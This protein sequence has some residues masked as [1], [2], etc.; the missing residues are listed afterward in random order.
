M[1]RIIYLTLLSLRFTNSL[2]G[3]D[4]SSARF[5]LHANIKEGALLHVYLTQAGVHS[6]LVESYSEIDFATMEIEA[7]KEMVVAYVKEHTQIIG[8]GIEMQ[9]GVGA[10]KLGSHETQIKL[11]LKNYPKGVEHLVVTIDAFKENKHHHSLF[12]WHTPEESFRTILSNKND[13]EG[14]FELSPVQPEVHIASIGNGIIKWLFL[15]VGIGFLVLAFFV[16]RQEL[17]SISIS[18][19]EK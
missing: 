8:D 13:F 16:T 7:Y 10:I 1:K 14:E 6:A 19:K 17:K 2:F 18:R 3:H 11:H 15:F 9:F 5:E 4:P 12:W